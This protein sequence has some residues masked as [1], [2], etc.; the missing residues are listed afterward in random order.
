MK[1]KATPTIIPPKVSHK[2]LKTTYIGFTK[3]PEKMS[4]KMIKNT[5]EIPLFNKDSL[6]SNTLNH[7][8]V[9]ISLSN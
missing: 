2:K 9:L 3:L 1:L 8:F 5:T 4:E 7:L 6:S